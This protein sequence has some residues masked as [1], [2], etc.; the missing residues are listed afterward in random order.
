[1]PT[2]TTRRGKL[3]WRA[4]VKVN[5]KIVASKWFGGGTKE[6]RKAV[7]WEEEWKHSAL[8][9]KSVP[10]PKLSDWTLAYLEDVQIRFAHSTFEE[11]R[12][13]MTRLMK[14]LG[15][16]D[17]TVI[18]P[19]VA[20]RFLENQCQNRSGYSANRDRKNL[21]AGWTW[22]RKFMD[23]FPKTGNP[24][25]DV[26]KFPEER[27]PRYVPPEEDFW[28]VLEVAQGQDRVMLTAFLYTA[29]RRDELFRLTWADVDF[30]ENVLLLRT[31]K[32]RGSSWRVDPLPILPELR[33]ALVW[34]WNARPYK[35][36]DHVFTCLNDSP[37]PNHNPGGRFKYRLHF[38]R[39]LC[40]R[41]HV[42]PFGFHAI[43]HLRA[44]M[45]YKGGALVHEIQKWLRHESASTTERYLKSLGCDLDRLQE[46]ATRGKEQAKVIPFAQ[47]DRTPRSVAPG[48]S[49]YPPV[50]PLAKT[51]ATER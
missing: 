38:M 32:T 42:K 39:R 45:L 23:G 16:Q 40:E 29:A 49:G 25:L 35:S 31:R 46:A 36:A 17:V 21:A 28:R 14:S 15:D 13:A 10:V 41:A 43:R 19:G 8:Q 44:V 30:N 24:F 12:T 4:V 18:T 22:A 47:N 26:D 34:W 27:S 1:M 3:R 33:Q 51:M 50:Y 6:H 37:S 5:G 2:E 7:L 20:L 48:G 11:K 9:Q